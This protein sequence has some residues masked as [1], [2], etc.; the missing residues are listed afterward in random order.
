MFDSELHHHESLSGMG[1]TPSIQKGR[2]NADEPW[3]PK[4]SMPIAL[5]RVM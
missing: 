1:T 5:F 4:P 3:P 2:H